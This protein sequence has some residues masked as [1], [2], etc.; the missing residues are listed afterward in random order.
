MDCEKYSF[1][2]MKVEEIVE[3]INKL[4]FKVDK[5]IIESNDSDTIVEL[6]C[7][8]LDKLGIIK[9]VLGPK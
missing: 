3:F 4:G 9:K 8:I 2:L 7:S 6:F 1:P 5:T